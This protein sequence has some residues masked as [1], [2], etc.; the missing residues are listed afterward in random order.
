MV[1]TTGV[2]ALYDYNQFISQPKVQLY[3]ANRSTVDGAYQAA[4]DMGVNEDAR[5]PQVLKDL[6]KE[7]GLEAQGD[8]LYGPREKVMA[9]FAGD[10]EVKVITVNDGGAYAFLRDPNL[11]EKRYMNYLPTSLQSVAAYGGPG[12]QQQRGAQCGIG[13]LLGF[14]GAAGVAILYCAGNFVRITL[15]ERRSKNALTPNL[16]A[17]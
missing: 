13:A 7:L 4:W 15:N 5:R 2:G 1:T 3:L 9:T 11:F 12:Y 16:P 17:A 6:G 10:R 14:F 8:H